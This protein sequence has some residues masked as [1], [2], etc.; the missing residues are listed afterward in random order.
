ML[1]SHSLPVCVHVVFYVE[2]IQISV[3]I[4]IYIKKHLTSISISKYKDIDA[5]EHHY[6]SADIVW[7][8]MVCS[9]ISA[10]CMEVST[11]NSTYCR[12]GASM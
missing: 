7:Y 5:Y 6:K 4:Y 12:Y 11:R 3:Y 10:N 9:D 2:Y 8:V 1:T